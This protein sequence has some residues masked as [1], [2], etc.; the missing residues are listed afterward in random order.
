[1]SDPN[2]FPT[3]D[4]APAPTQDP[5]TPPA[6]D[7]PSTGGDNPPPNDP[8]AP[9]FFDSAP[10]TWRQDW[11]AKA[12]FEGEDAE[13]RL[14]QLNR[15]T[16]MPSVLKSYFEAQDKIRSGEI[17]TG[18]PENPTDEQL[19]DWRQAN[20]VP[21]AADGYELSLSEG[22]V[23]GEEDKAIMD[24]V[25]AAAHGENISNQ[26]MSAITDAFLK[27]RE[28]E[29]HQIE[30]QDGLDTQSAT[31]ALKDVWGPDYKTNINVI[32]N[33]V[34][35]LP[36]SVREDFQ[37][38]RLANGK[39]LFNSPEAMVF[40]AD[41]ARKLNPAATVVNANDANPVQTINDEISTL[42]KKME[43]GIADGTWHK[44]KASND[45]L[46]ELYEARDKMQAQG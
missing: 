7:P 27:G 34:N 9:A 2:D 19:A 23:L 3:G 29:L 16:D 20:G 10:E 32:N 15:M 38:A 4:P 25:Y 12:G 42:E 26:A 46:M 45:R 1:M 36:E 37:N 30:Q 41:I 28:Q 13:K 40:F 24:G 6:G 14:G 35:T 17:S 11:L 33:L 31:A 21:A 43:E 22:L 44:D 8:P 5:A 39:G 18:L